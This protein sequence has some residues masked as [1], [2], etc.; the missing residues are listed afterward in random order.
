MEQDKNVPS[1]RS[2][3]RSAALTQ[4]AVRVDPLSQPRPTFLAIMAIAGGGY[5]HDSRG[6]VSSEFHE[7]FA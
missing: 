7:N 3:G 6:R 5:R 4:I 2:V 1:L